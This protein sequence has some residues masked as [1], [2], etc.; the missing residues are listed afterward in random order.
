MLEVE[1][2]FVS[3]QV[4]VAKQD[5]FV[6]FGISCNHVSNILSGKMILMKSFINLSYISSVGGALI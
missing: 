4:C 3:K 2:R 6:N 5:T 1:E